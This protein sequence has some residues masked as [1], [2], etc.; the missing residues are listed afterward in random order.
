[1]KHYI[2]FIDDNEKLRESMQSFFDKEG[3]VGKC[4][5][6]GE[7]GIALVRQKIFTFSVAMVDYHLPDMTGAQVI[8][9]LRDVDPDLVALGF[10]DDK[11]DPVHNLAM[12]SGAISFVNKDAGDAKLLGILHRHCR[13]FE[14]RKKP[15]TI[16]SRATN[17]KLIAPLDMAGCSNHLADVTRL[18]LKYAMSS[19]TVLVRGEN[20]TGK[21]KIARAIHDHSSRRLMPYIAVNCAAFPKDLIES[22]LFGH[23]KGSFTGASNNK[24]G[25]FQAANGGTIFLDE[26]GELDPSVQSVL[27]RVLQEKTFMAVGSNKTQK[28]D[29]RVVA[30]TNAPLEDLIAKKMFRQDLFFRLNVLPIHLRPLRERPEDIPYLIE[31]FLARINKN[32][33]T[34][35]FILQSAVDVLMKMPW[36][37]NVRELEHAIEYLSIVCD[38]K[39]LDIS[40]LKDRSPTASKPSP[41]H[42]IVTDLDA[43]EAVKESNE[44]EVVTRAMVNNVTISGAARALGISRTTLRDKLKKYGIKLERSNGE[45]VNL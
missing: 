24:I 27:L 21:E 1:M 26:I 32:A 16:S 37:G 19:L 39:E 35:K 44:C 41:K 28:V 43:V 9:R 7:E 3:F 30:A 25:K 4:V 8:A 15:L 13:E 23:E 42:R 12:D 10:S 20:G 11:S 6:T 33:A 34:E 31:Y 22:E 38:G 29:V 45:E 14:R 18:V 40:T 2:L 36:P 5:A 17:Q